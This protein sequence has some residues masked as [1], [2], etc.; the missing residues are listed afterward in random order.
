MCI[1]LDIGSRA[2]E[3]LGQSVLTSDTNF[4]FLGHLISV[5]PTAII[6]KITVC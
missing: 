4:A 6:C 3:G 5:G 2:E 1:E